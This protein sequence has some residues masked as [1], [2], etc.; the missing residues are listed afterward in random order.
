VN[1]CFGALLAGATHAHGIASVAGTG[2]STCGRNRAGATFRTFAGSI[3]EG[4]G[5]H[6][7][8]RAAIDAL[9]QE[10]HGSAA[11]TALTP[12]LLDALGYDSTPALFEA[13]MRA[14]ALGV[15]DS[16]LARIVSEVAAAGDLCAREVMRAAG[17]QHGRDVVGVA[18]RLDMLFDETEVVCAG[19]V[20]RGDA[21]F[22]EAFR[23][24]VR[25]RVPAATFVRLDAPP[26]VGAAVLALDHTGVDAEARA[27]A[28]ARL[29]AA[30][31]SI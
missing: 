18:R 24:E 17:V 10:H 25:L 19:G 12:A 28:R 8:V 9:A 30:L 1:D 15:F 22:G 16:G 11:P 20:H 27:A 14:H 6:G 4:S 3:G 5:A 2:G 7:I 31:P 23:A 26:V 29:A 13:L 21:G